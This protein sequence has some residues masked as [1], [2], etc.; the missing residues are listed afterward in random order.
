MSIITDNDFYKLFNGKE[1]IFGTNT[2]FL[3]K[4]KEKIESKINK[5]YHD[6]KNN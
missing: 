5:S 6:K 2:E 1:N 3:C 4:Q